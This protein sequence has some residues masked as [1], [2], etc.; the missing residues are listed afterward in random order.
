M[1]FI[2]SYEV[3]AVAWTTNPGGKVGVWNVENVSNA[4]YQI[5]SEVIPTSK[6]QYGFYGIRLRNSIGQLNLK[7]K[8]TR[9]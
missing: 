9:M 2:G 1:F 5:Y 8:I 7:V 3:P 4:L 6:S